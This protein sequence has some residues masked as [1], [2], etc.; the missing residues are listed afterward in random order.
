VAR[1]MVWLATAQRGIDDDAVFEESTLGPRWSHR[2]L[3][4]VRQSTRVA[5]HRMRRTSPAD[6]S[7]P[8]KGVNAEVGE[9][10]LHTY[11]KMREVLP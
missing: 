7:V 9:A 5:Q 1:F 3:R 10:S 2:A 4:G 11:T 6:G 8:V